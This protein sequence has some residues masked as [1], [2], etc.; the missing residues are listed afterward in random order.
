MSVVIQETRNA[1]QA[2]PLSTAEKKDQRV[3]KEANSLEWHM[4][5]CCTTWPIQSTPIHANSIQAN[6]NLNTRE[7]QHE[8]REKKFHQKICS[9]LRWNDMIN[10]TLIIELNARLDE[11]SLL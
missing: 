1:Q 8:K 6:T 11:A 7:K 2:H 5:I 10:N 3:K 4:Q 9:N